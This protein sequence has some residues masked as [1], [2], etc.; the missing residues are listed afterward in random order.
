MDENEYKLGKTRP[1]LSE[2]RPP[3][4]GREL[5]FHVQIMCARRYTSFHDVSRFNSNPINGTKLWLWH[6]QYGQMN[7]QYDCLSDGGKDIL[8][9]PINYV[10]ENLASTCK[11]SKNKQS[12]LK[13]S[14]PNTDPTE[15]E[16]VLKSSHKIQ[17]IIKINQRYRSNSV[18]L[19]KDHCSWTFN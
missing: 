1:P 9:L 7:G 5:D 10:L 12:K 17:Q 4:P 14:K 16:N 2:H 8:Y 13:T 3:P 18:S 6:Y 19:A 11:R 15:T